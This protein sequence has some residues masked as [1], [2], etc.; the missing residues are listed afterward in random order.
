MAHTCVKILTYT[1]SYNYV[2]FTQCVDFFCILQRV[3]RNFLWNYRRAP[4]WS[5]TALL[6]F[7]GCRST[8]VCLLFNVQRHLQ[9]FTKGPS[10]SLNP[11]ATLPLWNSLSAY[12]HVHVGYHYVLM[13]SLNVLSFI[14]YILH[15]LCHS[16]ILQIVWLRSYH[17]FKNQLSLN[18]MIQRG[19]TC[20]VELFHLTSMW[21]VVP[22]HQV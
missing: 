5:R 16:R 8:V 2:K 11:F 18:S 21:W 4:W 17:D 10:W 13:S 1:C 19:L 12:I 15:N 6:C 9:S 7:H 20:L 22:N 3:Q 14:L